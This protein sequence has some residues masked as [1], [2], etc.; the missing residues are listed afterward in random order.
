MAIKEKGWLETIEGDLVRLRASA[1]RL[2]NAGE[3]L[4]E[5]N[6]RLKAASERVARLAT[7]LEQANLRLELSLVALVQLNHYLQIMA[8][9]GDT[10]RH[11]PHH[12]VVRLGTWRKQRENDLPGP[13][14]Q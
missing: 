8:R 10:T 3:R 9:G 12:R 14:V 7:V 5:A 4:S 6:E 1:E 2:N 11:S 13:L